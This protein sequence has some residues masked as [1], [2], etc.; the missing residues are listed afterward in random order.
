MQIIFSKL[1]S[2]RY[3]YFLVNVKFSGHSVNRLKICSNHNKYFGS[4]NVKTSK[5]VRIECRVE[6]LTNLLN[7]GSIN[8]V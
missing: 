4:P 8:D 3:Y 1:E 2:L 6:E 5:L 7:L